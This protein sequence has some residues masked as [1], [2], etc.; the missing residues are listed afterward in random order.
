MGL[1]RVDEVGGGS[2]GEVSAREVVDVLTCVGIVAHDVAAVRGAGRGAFVHPYDRPP[3]RTWGRGRVTLLGDA[4]HPM[5]PNIGQGAAQALED[6]VVLG[7]CAAERRNNPEEILREY[8]RRRIRRANAAV[9]ASRR[10]SRTAEVTSR[11]AARLRDAAMKT[12]PD[13]LTVAQLRGM[14]EFD[15]RAPR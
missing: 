5:K 15:P 14:F 3:R 4:A 1:V 8:E 7:V 12:L 11:T 13:R 10:T 6:A 9:R 2:V